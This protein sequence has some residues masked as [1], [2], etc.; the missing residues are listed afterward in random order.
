MKRLG[1]VVLLLFLAAP[2]IAQIP[3]TFTNLK[4][5]PEDITRQ[6]LT[7]IMRGFTQALGVRCS[8]C[9]MGEEGQP[10]SEYDF[11]SDER[12]TKQTARVM[13]LMVRAINT[14]YLTEVGADI[15]V[16]CF[17]CHHGARKPQPLEDVLV[18]AS[19]AG[20]PDSLAAAYE[21]YREQYYGRA[22]FDFGPQSLVDAASQLRRV[23][24]GMPAALRALVM[25]TERFPDDGIGWVSYGQVL[26]ATGDTT[27]AISALERAGALL[28]MN[29]Q[30]Q[31]MIDRLGGQ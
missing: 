1:P 18:A 4:V 23:P 26:A 21:G 20:G 24:E 6:Q 2:A 15:E 31:R 28:G 8:T 13:L 7:G 10:L 22:V 19:L 27:G 14:E 30:L 3:D 9:H 25:Q 16:Q 11:A 29:P 12:E 5:L 17:T